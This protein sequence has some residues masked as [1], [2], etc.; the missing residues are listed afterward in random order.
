MRLVLGCV[1]ACG[2]DLLCIFERHFAAEFY[3][4][5]RNFPIYELLFFLLILLNIPLKWNTIKYLNIVIIFL[6]SVIMFQN[7]IIVLL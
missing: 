4:G 6:N 7:S 5:M 1:G 2:I 3:P